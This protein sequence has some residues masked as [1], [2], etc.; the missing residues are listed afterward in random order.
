MKYN[1]I[2]FMAHQRIHLVKILFSHGAV[3]QPA[4]NTSAASTT[5]CSA[6]CVELNGAHLCTVL[7]NVVKIEVLDGKHD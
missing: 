4:I 5:S 2:T 7:I 6:Q 3:V 1:S